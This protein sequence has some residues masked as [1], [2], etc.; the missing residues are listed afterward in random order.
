MNTIFAIIII[1]LLLIIIS[2]L[3]SI[4]NWLSEIWLKL[5]DSK[6]ESGVGGMASWRIDKKTKE[7]KR[8]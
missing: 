8:G 7:L 1:L 5:E 4:D 2:F 3:R 6:E